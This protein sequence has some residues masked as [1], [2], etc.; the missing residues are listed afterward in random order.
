M[1]THYGKPYGVR[2]NTF[3]HPSNQPVTLVKRLHLSE[4]STTRGQI[5]GISVMLIFKLRDALLR[6]AIEQSALQ[7]AHTGGTCERTGYV[8]EL[9]F[10]EVPWAHCKSSLGSAE[11]S[12]CSHPRTT[13]SVQWTRPLFFLCKA[14]CVDL[15]SHL[16]Q[17]SL[18][19]PHP[20]QTGG[21]LITGNSY[22]C[23]LSSSEHF[24][25]QARTLII[26]N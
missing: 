10:Q 21:C 22:L 17:H 1:F 2:G 6:D 23:Q 5:W 8:N 4:I 16:L 15:H 11:V 24:Q 18:T 3:S 20:T 19:P 26:F 9:C 7:K 13:A 12:W 14:G 25:T